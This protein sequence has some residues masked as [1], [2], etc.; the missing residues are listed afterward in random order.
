M[1]L[2]Y[3]INTQSKLS[4]FPTEASVLPAAGASVFYFTRAVCRNAIC[5]ISGMNPPFMRVIEEFAADGFTHVQCSCPRCRMMRLRPISWLPRIA[6]A[7]TLLL[8]FGV[9]P[10]LCAP[11]W[12]YDY[13]W[14]QASQ[15][16]FNGRGDREHFLANCIADHVPTPPAKRGRYKKPR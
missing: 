4:P 13:C 3:Q 1:R 12:V 7:A 9:T 2:C 5:Y 14:A 16:Q 15:I 8:L 6:M 10:A 11:Q